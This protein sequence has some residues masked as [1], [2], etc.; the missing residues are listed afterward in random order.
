MKAIEILKLIEQQD[1]DLPPLPSRAEIMKRKA[2]HQ[3]LM[4]QKKEWDLRDQR[5]QKGR[6][7]G[8]TV[9]HISHE[10]EREKPDADGDPIYIEVECT[11]SGNFV[12]GQRQTYY[13]PG[14]PDSFEDIY[15]EWA[16]PVDKNPEGGPLTMKEKLDIEKWFEESSTQDYAQQKLRDAYDGSGY[17]YEYDD[18]D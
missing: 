13:E 1:D 3:R 17:D 18:R 12:K 7:H 9:A 15:L 4:A 11:I 10:L 2:E 16:E 6:T 14:Y 8:D 5:Q